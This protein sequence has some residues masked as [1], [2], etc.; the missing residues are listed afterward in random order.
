MGVKEKAVGVLLWNESSPRLMSDVF[1][2]ACSCRMMYAGAAFQP[3][4]TECCNVPFSGCGCLEALDSV[5]HSSITLCAIGAQQIWRLYHLSMC[6]CVFYLY[7]G[8]N[9]S[10]DESLGPQPGV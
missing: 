6:V 10:R 8:I 1:R 4:M 5:P 7:S 9:H 2:A 3:L